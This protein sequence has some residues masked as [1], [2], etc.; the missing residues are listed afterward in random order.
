MAVAGL[1]GTRSGLGRGAELLALGF[2]ARG[3]KVTRIDLTRAAGFPME[4]DVARAVAPDELDGVDASDILVVINPPHFGRALRAIPV[5]WL[6]ERSIVGHWVWE[7]D[8]APDHW[9]ASAAICDEIWAPS[10]FVRDALIKTMPDCA[11]RIR[12]MAYPT[13]RDPFRPRSATERAEARAS[14]GVAADSFCVGYSFAAG[15]SYHR[16]NPEA[17]VAAFKTAF[18][19]GERNVLLLRCPDLAAHAAERQRLEKLCGGDGR[20]RLLVGDAAGSVSRFYH[21]I[22]VYLAPFRSEGF[23][24]PLIEAAQSGARV[25]ATGYGLADEIKS[26]PALTQIPYRLIPLNDPQ[27]YYESGPGVVWA[28]PDA[29]ALVDALRAGADAHG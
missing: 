28:E 10:S 3:S 13:E 6:S 2:E 4:R 12:L 24:L 29:N 20:I 11:S 17:A 19:H 8:A 14:F 5:D 25:I 18:P 16:K 9:R 27:G 1:F 15:S 7:L 21:A 23:G 26:L 22:D